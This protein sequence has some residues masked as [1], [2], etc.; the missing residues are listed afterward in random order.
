MAS[1]S[2]GEGFIRPFFSTLQ[3]KYKTFAFESQGGEK[4]MNTQFQSSI[5]PLFSLLSPRKK[6]E[7]SFVWNTHM[8]CSEFLIVIKNYRLPSTPTR[9]SRGGEKRRN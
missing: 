5:S 9:D 8:E 7:K 2:T 3:M 4:A 1:A 6:H